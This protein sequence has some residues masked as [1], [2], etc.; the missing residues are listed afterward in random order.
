MILM[1]KSPSERANPK[2]REEKPQKD[3]GNKNWLARHE[4]V[5]GVILL[6]GASIPDFRIR[7]AQSELRHDMSPSHWSLCGI[8]F[9]KGRFASVTLNLPQKTSEIPKA[10]GIRMCRIEEFN[11][12]KW[13]PNIAVIRFAKEHENL[14]RDIGRLEM[15]RSILDIPTLILPWL[16]FVWGTVGSGN[17]LKNGLG[18]PSAAFVE[19]IFAM[20]GF[21]LTPGLSSSSSCPEAIWQSAR[22]WNSYFEQASKSSVSPEAV[23]MA[24]EGVYTL[25]QEFAAPVE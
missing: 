13:F 22:W 24:P 9:P 1:K 14:R 10:N 7:V 11:D 15:D 23:S 8:L 4:A 5:E 25:R 16:G 17:P 18:L 21:E 3:E 19:T 20:A 12:P 2:L 6:G